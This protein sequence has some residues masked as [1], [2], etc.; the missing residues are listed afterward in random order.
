MATNGTIVR[1]YK[2]MV[3]ATSMREAK[4]Y[5]EMGIYKSIEEVTDDE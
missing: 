3:T 5:L 4:D 2:V 1:H